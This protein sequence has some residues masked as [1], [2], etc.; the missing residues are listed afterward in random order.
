MVIAVLLSAPSAGHPHASRLCAVLSAHLCPQP[1]VLWGAERS[2]SGSPLHPA[3]PL[4]E[5]QGQGYEAMTGRNV[6]WPFPSLLLLLTHITPSLKSAKLLV[7]SSLTPGPQHYMK[8]ILLPAVLGILIFC[9]TAAGHRQVTGAKERFLHGKA[10]SDPCPFFPPHH[11]PTPTATCWK[12]FARQV[13]Y[14]T[15]Q[16][17]VHVAGVSLQ[18]THDLC[19][20]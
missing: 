13:K 16:K 2:T 4:Q 6:S 8:L 11:I 19:V 7:H 5:S 14:Y 20:L 12:S 9:F 18:F 3:E 17:E 15:A 1:E 10:T